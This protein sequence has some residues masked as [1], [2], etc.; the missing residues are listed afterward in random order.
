MQEGVSRPPPEQLR[1]SALLEGYAA[2]IT[3]ELSRQ[4]PDY[5]TAHS[6]W[7]IVSRSEAAFT[8]AQVRHSKIR[9]MLSYCVTTGN[10]SVLVYI[11]TVE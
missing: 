3:W 7:T 2:N 6:R 11:V 5:R 1:L 4:T 8:Y 10:H 9:G